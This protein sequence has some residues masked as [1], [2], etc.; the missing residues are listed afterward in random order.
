MKRGGDGRWGKKGKCKYAIVDHKG[1]HRLNLDIGCETTIPEQQSNV[2]KLNSVSQEA[3]QVG[4][5]CRP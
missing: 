2:S 1:G 4:A 5:R 3:R